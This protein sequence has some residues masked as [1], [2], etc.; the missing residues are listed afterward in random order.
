MGNRVNTV[1]TLFYSIYKQIV[2]SFL[3]AVDIARPLQES[4]R[5]NKLKFFHKS[6]S[7][8]C[9]TPSAMPTN[10]QGEEV[11]IPPKDEEE[12]LLEK[13]VFEMPQGLKIT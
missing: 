6:I 1:R 7:Y 13:L 4:H 9:T 5:T 10:I 12:I 3:F 11:I 8:I 2:N